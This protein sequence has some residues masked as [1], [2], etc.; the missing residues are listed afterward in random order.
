MAE[1]I[2]KLSFAGPVHFGSRR[3]S[4]GTYTCD[5]ATL[6]SALYVEAMRA[7][8]ADEL[9][10]AAKVGDLLLSDAFPYVGEELYVPKP[11]VGNVRSDA[12]RAT[13]SDSRERKANKKLKYIP[14]SALDDFLTGN[15]D[16]I[17]ALAQFELG[18][19]FART[20]V[21]LTREMSDDAEPYHVGAFSFNP[22][23]G[24]YFVVRGAYD[25]DPLFEQLGYSG[26]GG[27]R[28]SGY[29]RFS[30]RVENAGGFRFADAPSGRAMLLS[31]S[32]P[33]ERE[34]TDELVD[35]AKY[36][37]ARKGGFVQSTTH[38]DSFRKKRDMWAFTP[39]SV[40]P[41]G[42]DGDVFDVNATPGS[43][44]VY[45]YARAMW[46]EV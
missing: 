6:F 8:C 2:I 44:P 37:L 46:M 20:K 16:F 29:G 30:A 25:A 14:L 10:H 19:S 21:N 42:F 12:K 9:L 36:H 4:D 7:G 34:L 1:R 32:C 39:G 3:L 28:T 31:S 35:G 18:T 33:K 38:A 13:A 41:H 15:F 26:I 27:K 24:I 17:G 23:C 40:F 45:R 22:G 11:M 43:H 5:A